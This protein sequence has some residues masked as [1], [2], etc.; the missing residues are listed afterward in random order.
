MELRRTLAGVPQLD[1]IKPL[2][3]KGHKDDQF[4]NNK[5]VGVGLA[6]PKIEIGMA[7]PKINEAMSLG[8]IPISGKSS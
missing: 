6:E 8:A 7:K 2:E 5:R 1:L 4:I 3:F